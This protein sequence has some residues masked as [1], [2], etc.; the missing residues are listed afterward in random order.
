MWAAVFAATANVVEGSD[1]TFHI[2]V[3]GSRPTEEVVV[4]YETEG[5]A[6]SGD[7]YTAPSG[8]VT[9]PVGQRSAPIAIGTTADG[10]HDPNETLVVRLTEITSVGRTVRS[11]KETRTATV[12]ILDEATPVVSVEGEDGTEGEALQFT[13]NLSSIT[14]A[15]VEVQWETEQYGSFL[16]LDEQATPGADYEDA[17]GTVTIPPGEDTGAFTVATTQDDLAEN[18]E[19]FLVKLTG[20]SRVPG[21]GDPENVTL[22]A[23]SAEGLILDDD[24]PPTAITLSA[25]PV[26]VPGNA[27][28]TVL[29]ITA[30][31]NTTTVL[32]EDTSVLV[33]I[34]GGTATE[35]EDY[36]A[37]T[38]T[39]IIA[40]GELSRT[41]VLHLTPLNDEIVEG[42]ETA[43]ITGTADGLDVTPAEVTITDD[44]D[45]PTGITLRVTPNSVSEGDGD[46][47]L[48]IKAVL[49]GGDRRPVDTMVTLSVQGA[50]LPVD[51][52]GDTSNIG[53]AETITAASFDDFS[54]SP[55]S[56]EGDA[57]PP[58]QIIPAGE[59][60]ATARLTLTVVDD[61]T[62]EGDETALVHGTADGLPVTPAPLTITD[63][64]RDPTGIQLS[65]TPWDIG[66]GDG[67]MDLLVTATL[68]GGAAR[69]ADTLVSLSVHGLSALA[70]EDYSEPSNVTLTIPAESLSGAATL[71]LTLLDDDISEDN[72]DL[73]VRG[74]NAAPGFP[75]T[76][77]LVS[78]DDNDA[79]PTGVTLSLDKNHVSEDA[80]LQQLTVTGKLTG[81]SKRSVDTSA[82]RAPDSIWADPGNGNAMA[83]S[84]GRLGRRR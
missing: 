30:M 9:I 65:V 73:K 21:T 7:D 28:S 41:G 79:E 2:W 31:L 50:A 46:T 11:N 60:D 22:G 35:G 84:D 68:T 37:T 64:D 61:Q 15:P 34:A 29:V 47:V 3:S 43:Q 8:T 67:A 48:N 72:E 1:A 66:E 53:A 80:E 42:D 17:T 82:R 10:L 74:T 71:T 55:A 51:G 39:L 6:T 23:F 63:N 81:G 13:V 54:V 78:I 38:A 20:A 32:T 40:S 5:T 44:D 45:E 4:E 12:T 27:D 16:P 83:G 69:T 77:A 26:A 56:P 24:E 49:T 14:D 25:T 70:G 58:G 52:D 33:T 59:I 57:D 18:T 62:A 19:R 76:G 36:T 75:V